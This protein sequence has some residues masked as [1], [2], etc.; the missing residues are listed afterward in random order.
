MFFRKGKNKAKI[1]IK[2]LVNKEQHQYNMKKK[3]RKKE[4]IEWQ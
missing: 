2:G 4:K 1:Q 3:K